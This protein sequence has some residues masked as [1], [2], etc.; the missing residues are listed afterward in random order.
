MLQTWV[1]LVTKT[2]TQPK[3]AQSERPELNRGHNEQF[4]KKVSEYETEF[5]IVRSKKSV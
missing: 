4:Q 3:L 5:K 1:L 2:D